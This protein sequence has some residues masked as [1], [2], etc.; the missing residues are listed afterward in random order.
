MTPR[1]GAARRLVRGVVPVLVG[2]LI[3][4]AVALLVTALLHKRYTATSRVLVSATGVEN[5]SQSSARTNTGINLDTE[6]QLVKSAAV[7]ERATQTYRPLTK[8]TFEDLVSDISVTVPPNTT[9]LEIAFT[10]NAAKVARAGANALAT[11][12]LADRQGNAQNV[13]D[14]QKRNAQQSVAALTSELQNVSQQAAASKTNGYLRTRIAL[15]KNQIDSENRQIVTLGTV[16]ITPG[17]VI[18]AASLPVK[19]SSPSMI[20]NLASGIGLGLILGLL[21]AWLLLRYRRKVRRPD[22]VT[23]VVDMPCLA[24]LS[25]PRKGSAARAEQYRRLALVSTS[26]VHDAR[27]LVFATPLIS[28]SGNQVAAEVAAALVRGGTSTVMLR[29]NAPDVNGRRPRGVEMLSVPNAEAVSPGEPLAAGL[30]RARG[31]HDLLV[32]AAGGASTTADAAAVAALA[33]AVVLVVD[34]GTR[35]RHVR[36]AVR[37]LDEVGAPMLGV[38]LVPKGKATEP[39]DPAA[40]NSP[41]KRAG[42]NAA[43]QVA[44]K[45]KDERSGAKHSAPAKER[46]AKE[47]VEEAAGD[48]STNAGAKDGASADER[49]E[50]VVADEPAKDVVADERPEDVVAGDAAADDPPADE[51]AK[52]AAADDPP[53]DE[54]AKDVVADEPAE[55]VVA[56]EPAED[57]P[58]KDVVAGTPTAKSGTAQSRRR[59]PENAPNANRGKSGT[60]DRGRQSPASRSH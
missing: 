6:A 44:T 4:A 48:A 22:D 51:P 28:P 3:G 11:A 58:A 40:E 31:D 37:A 49:P 60:R 45:R 42:K 24:V 59:Q 47:E 30:D 55:D 50:D 52:D 36:A 10:A 35:S 32:V 15:V 23:H 25:R 20:I 33:D 14:R 38:V 19:A 17:R 41:N 34:V 12:Y 39:D 8:Q 53:A 21:A 16:Q 54:P 29:V 18:T 43:A 7:V 26:A 27:R 56:D 1:P 2:M 9:V 57:E 46:P 13:L 5:T